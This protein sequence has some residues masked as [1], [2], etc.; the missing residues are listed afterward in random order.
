M[1][2][3]SWGREAAGDGAQGRRSMG[4]RSRTELWRHLEPGRREDV[5]P[6][7]VFLPSKEDSPGE[8]NPS[9]FAAV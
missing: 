1:G 5:G 4:N 9:L 6:S 8:G 3:R 7:K 2:A